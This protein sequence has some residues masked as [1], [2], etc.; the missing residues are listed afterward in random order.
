MSD[1]E[2]SQNLIVNNNEDMDNDAEDM[3]E[4]SPQ[5]RGRKGKK[6]NFTSRF[7][8]FHQL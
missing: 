3:N 2:S 7:V 6:E 1:Q 5:K 4:L 8:I